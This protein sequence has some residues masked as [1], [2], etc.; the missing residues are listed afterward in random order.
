M[1]GFGLY[2][3]LGR[4]MQGGQLLVTHPDPKPVAARVQRCAA[5]PARVGRSRPDQLD[6]HLVAFH[7]RPTP[8]P[9]AEQPST[10]PLGQMRRNHGEVAARTWSRCTFRT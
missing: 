6:D 7:C 5:P 1:S 3:V 2:G 9:P 4:R 10:L 8:G